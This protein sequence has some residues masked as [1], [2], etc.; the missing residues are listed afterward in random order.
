VIC[1]GP[2]SHLRH[3]SAYLSG[4]TVP[5]ASS[6]SLSVWDHGPTCIV[7]QVICLGP[8]SHLRRRSRYLPGT[9]VPPASSVSLS[10]W[11]HGPTC[12]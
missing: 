6:V 4:T 7:C 2:R 9:T 8:R 10:V 3:R 1:L 5:P 11:D 12:V